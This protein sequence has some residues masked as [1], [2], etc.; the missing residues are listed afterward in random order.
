VLATDS[1]ADWLQRLG[2]GV[3]SPRDRAERS[4][5]LTFACGDTAALHTALSD[6][7]AWSASGSAAS[8]WR[9]TSI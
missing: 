8:G 5:I 9:R 3:L 6:A 2:A 1:L 4:A 7:G